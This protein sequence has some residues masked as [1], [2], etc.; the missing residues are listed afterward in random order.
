[1]KN[2][3]LIGAAGFVAPRH[4]A[5]IRDTGNRLVAASD[6]NDSV[7]ILDRYSL[8]VRFFREIERF[9]RFL[10]KLRR[11]PDPSR[12]DYLSIC[13]PNY[14]HDAHLR[15]ALRAGAD[16]ICEKPLVINP[17]N[18]DALQ[19]LERDTGRRVWTV[20]QL[21]VHPA[22]VALRE[23]LAKSSGRHDVV[24]S[25]V[26]ARGGW[27]DVSWKGSEERSGG[28]AANIGIHFFDLLLWL[29][30]PVQEVEVQLRE[31]RRMAGTL[32][33]ERANVRWFLSV[34]AADLPEESQPG[35]KMTFRSITVDGKEIEF[36]E[37]FN[38]LHTRVYERTLAGDGFGIEE[39]RPS[40][41]L[42]YRIRTAPVTQRSGTP[43]EA[44]T[45]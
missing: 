28:V 12:I 10:E 13:S 33:L 26:T 16:A 41:E 7:G 6:P 8:D 29:F 18:L 3:A 32:V 44:A 40:I 9:D 34:N 15:L 36:T 1:M 35:G 43:H 23:S 39:A 25:Y 37:G 30:G 21:R 24:L 11:G 5:A 17:W 20:L 2:F 42:V 19:D 14:L 27:Y 45:R 38:D 31:P 4:L 22:L